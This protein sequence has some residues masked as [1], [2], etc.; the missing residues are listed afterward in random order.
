MQCWTQFG[1]LDELTCVSYPN[2][3]VSD[4]V[5]QSV[6]KNGQIVPLPPSSKRYEASNIASWGMNSV[7]NQMPS[8][9]RVD[10]YMSWLK[11]MN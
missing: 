7:K 11:Y 1:S 3:A 5:T 4:M 9:K 10:R 8:T 6:V 2:P